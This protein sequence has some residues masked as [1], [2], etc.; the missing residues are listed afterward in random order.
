MPFYFFFVSLN[1]WAQIVVSVSPCLSAPSLIQTCF[2]SFTFHTNPFLFLFYYYFLI[3]PVLPSQQT[4]RIEHYS[5]LTGLLAAEMAGRVSSRSNSRCCCTVRGSV[6]SLA[7]LIHLWEKLPKT[8]PRPPGSA[9]GEQRPC[10]QLNFHQTSW[11]L[12]FWSEYA[13]VV[14]FLFEKWK[15]N[16]WLF[17]FYFRL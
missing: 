7:Q 10:L 13:L 4:E 8:F 1:I 6:M 11:C 15:K 12:L 14:R 3:E 17:Y 9:D 16:G 5:L 2:V